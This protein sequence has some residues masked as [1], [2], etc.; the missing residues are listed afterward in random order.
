MLIAMQDNMAL[1]LNQLKV[2]K[3]L[4]KNTLESYTRDL[5]RFHLF[6][7]NAKPSRDK[8]IQYLAHLYDQG[9]SATSVCRHLTSLRQFF[10][11]LL[12]EEK[13]KENPTS[14][15]DMPKTR[16]KLPQVLT[17]EEVIR[18]LDTPLQNVLGLRD[19]AMLE[20]LY[21][22]GCRVSE[23]VGLRLAS[24]DLKVGYVRVLGK[25]SKERL[26]PMGDM[27]RKKLERYLE[28]S[29]HHL[30]KKCDQDHVFLNQRGGKLTRQAFWLLLKKYAIK[31]EIEK[32]LTPHTLR[33]TF[34]T[35]L[36]ERG[37]DLRVIQ[38]L[39]GHS[40]I[41]STQIYTH[42]ST[43]KLEEVY[44]KYHPRA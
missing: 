38:A 4:A 21:A 28:E 41:S 30:D 40:D 1:F 35:H 39:L 32:D 27:A 36:L 9:L 3:G 14:D 16:K 37:A 11:F 42:I 19:R 18:L 17:E 20:V 2:E 15:I 6:L 23:L 13:I 31:A 12:Q 33:H 5:K 29:R 43:K 44:K 10:K 25:G 24:L 22:T 34:A 26:V 8:V 7:K